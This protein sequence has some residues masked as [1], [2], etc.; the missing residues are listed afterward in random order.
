MFTDERGCQEAK[1]CIGAANDSQALEKT[2]VETSSNEYMLRSAELHEQGCSSELPHQGNVLSY[3][4]P[5]PNKAFSL[6]SA[7][8]SA[9]VSCSISPNACWIQ[10]MLG[11]V[12]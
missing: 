8:T 2:C 6:F 11:N 10:L 3:D 1:T 5:V 4:L 7:C 9:H 12:S